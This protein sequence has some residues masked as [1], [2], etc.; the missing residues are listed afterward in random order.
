MKLYVWRPKGHG[1]LTFMVVAET[2]EDATIAVIRHIQEHYTISAYPIYEAQGFGG[3]YYQLE[4][5]EP[6]EVA[7]NNND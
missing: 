7:E 3:G 2:M 6:G 4:I 1:E 5:Y